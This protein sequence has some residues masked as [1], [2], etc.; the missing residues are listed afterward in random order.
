[1]VCA[2]PAQISNGLDEMMKAAHLRQN[3]SVPK[4]VGKYPD[5]ARLRLA[6][7]KAGVA[8]EFPLSKYPLHPNHLPSPAW[9]KID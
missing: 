9:S 8:D 4:P 7:G 2:N 6:E 3:V 5:R 1:M